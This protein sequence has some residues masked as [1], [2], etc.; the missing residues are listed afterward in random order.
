MG[1][2][3]AKQRDK[4]LLISKT[5]ITLHQLFHLSRG[6]L[7]NIHGNPAI[8]RACNFDFQQVQLVE[9]GGMVWSMLEIKKPCSFST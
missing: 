2:V 7:T 6:E 4:L 5:K 1:K 8:K 3:Q 9:L